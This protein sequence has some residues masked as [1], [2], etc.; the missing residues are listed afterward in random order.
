[1]NYVVGFM[2]SDEFMTYDMLVDS[3]E[4]TYYLSST[5][6]QPLMLP[7]DCVVDLVNKMR[8]DEGLD[9]PFFIKPSEETCIDFLE[10]CYDLDN[11]G[12]G[13]DSI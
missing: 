4:L 1:M 3:E 6:R 11:S 9:Y 5:D 13:E 10:R 12:L 2:A 7:E 8:T